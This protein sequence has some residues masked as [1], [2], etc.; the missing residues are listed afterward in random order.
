LDE[1]F[2]YFVR[3][4]LVRDLIVLNFHKEGKPLREYIDSVFRAA[5][6]L[7]YGASEQQ[8]FDRVVMNIHPSVLAHAAFMERPKSRA[9]LM[10]AVALIEERTAVAKERQRGEELT[11]GRVVIKLGAA[12]R[13]GV[14]QD[15]QD[16]VVVSH[17]CVGSV[18]KWV[19]L[20]E[21]VR[22]IQ[23]SRETSGRP[24]VGRPPGRTA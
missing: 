21:T 15:G 18:A 2:P 19:T 22:I 23:R 17:G 8:L 1:F 11:R 16:S 7:D 9:E 10:R 6:F 24:E 5:V 13:R 3:D 4:R 12:W 14:F 20:K